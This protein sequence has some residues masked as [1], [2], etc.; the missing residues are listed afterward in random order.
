MAIHNKT[1]VCI[2]LILVMLTT[3]LSAQKDSV[4]YKLGD[5]FDGL[6]ELMSLQGID[7]PLWMQKLDDPKKVIKESLIGCESPK[8]EVK[9][10]KGEILSNTSFSGRLTILEFSASW[11]RSC[12]VN[13]KVIFPV[14][15]E[16]DDSRLQIFYFSQDGK[17]H[18]KVDMP[19]DIH[20]ILGA[21]SVF[22]SFGIV[23]FPTTIIIDQTGHVIKY[24]TG[25]PF[26]EKLR[27]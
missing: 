21:K 25:A 15:E 12:I 14:Y 24:S 26:S 17:L 6:Y 23:S 27:N 1:R 20:V 16:L 5:C 13:S 18:S 4:N 19:D 10:S 2:F 7:I 8:F 11:C 9:D 22:E 3:E